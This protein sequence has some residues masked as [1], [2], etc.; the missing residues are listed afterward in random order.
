MEYS[1][2]DFKVLGD[3][4]GY[5]VAVEGER[6]I[7]FDIKRIY[8]IYDTERYAIRGRHAHH[9][10]EQAIIC[11]SG[12]CDFILEDGKERKTIHLDNPT[13]ALYIKNNIWREFTN[14][15]DGCVV[16]VLASEHYNSGDYI[17]D[18]KQFLDIK[19]TENSK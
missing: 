17:R 8:Y 2:I 5:L 11:V 3:E 4:R 13:Q 1:L 14:F 6:N 16:M 9:N 7:P 19:A 18:Y 10:L 12:A 15:T